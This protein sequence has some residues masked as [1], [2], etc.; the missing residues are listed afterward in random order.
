MYYSVTFAPHKPTVITEG[1][2]ASVFFPEFQIVIMIKIP[3]LMWKAQKQR[4]ENLV[5]WSL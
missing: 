5:I 2:S 1:V 3:Y 4:P